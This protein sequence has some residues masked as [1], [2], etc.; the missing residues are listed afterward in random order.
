MTKLTRRIN[1]TFDTE[2]IGGVGFCGP[3]WQEAQREYDRCKESAL[4]ADF[5]RE[6]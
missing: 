6:H 3:R 4:E 2:Y 5:A 1:R